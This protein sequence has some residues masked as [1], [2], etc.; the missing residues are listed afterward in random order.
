LNAVAQ[1][2]VCTEKPNLGDNF[3]EIGGDSINMVQVISRCFD[4]GFRIGITEFSLANNLTAIV[5]SMNVGDETQTDLSNLKELI[6]QDFGFIS[7]PLELEHKEVVIDMISRSFAEKGDLTTLANVTYDVIA[8]QVQVLWASLYKAGLS[9]VIKDGEKIIGAC[10]NFDARSEEAAPLC[11][12]AAFS[13]NMPTKN[14]E[15]N[16]NVDENEMKMITADDSA[17][18]HEESA[19]PMSVV[20]FLDAVEEPLKDQYLPEARGKTIYASLLG[21]AADLSPVD[22]VKITLYME[23]ENIRFGK[24]K[25]YEGIFTTNANR[26]TQHISRILGYQILSTIQVN[27]YEDANGSRPFAEAPDDLVTEVAL[28]WFE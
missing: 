20:E 14:D 26:L 5:S 28:K 11:A 4:Y 23:M 21:T 25:G 15:N 24:E 17:P 10:L 16:L 13:R 12:N 8:E 19:V 7:V 2:L 18:K 22:N 6:N 9:I 3:F 27:Q 1:V